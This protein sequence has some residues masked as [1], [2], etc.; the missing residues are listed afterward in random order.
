MN[1]NG[2][3]AHGT[4][5]GLADFLRS[6]ESEVRKERSKRNL[7]EDKVWLSACVAHYHGDLSETDLIAAEAL[8][9]AIAAESEVKR[10]NEQVSVQRILIE[11]QVLH[12]NTVN[13]HLEKIG[14]KSVVETNQ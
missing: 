10:L 2:A 12:I 3:M 13:T 8:D 4:L 5:P 6:K 14:H 7:E 11:A 9:R 1:N